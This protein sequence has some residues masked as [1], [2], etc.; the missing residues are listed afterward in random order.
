MA[1]RMDKRIDTALL[2]LNPTTKRLAWHGAPT[3]MGLLRGVTPT[4]ALWWPVPKAP[5]IWETALHVAFWQNSVANRLSQETIKFAPRM[6][7][8]TWPYPVDTLSR[9]EWQEAVTL[10]TE[11]HRRLVSVVAGFDPP[12]LDKPPRGSTNRPAIEFI[13]GIAEHN[14]YH[15]GQ[16]NLLKRLARLSRVK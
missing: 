10:V 12:A 15:G 8:Q 11:T 13:H 6:K 7:P 2:S 16:V 3:F 4:M 1:K 14:L 5:C 9:E